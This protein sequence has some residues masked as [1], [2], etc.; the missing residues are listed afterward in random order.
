MVLP[1]INLLTWAGLTLVYFVI[2]ALGT[3]NTIATTKLWPMTAANTGTL[4]YIIGVIG[5]YVCVTEG[6]INIVPI[7]LGAWLG[8]YYSVIWEIK[9][10]RK[11][12]KK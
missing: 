7:A 4:M 8:Q 10:K 9:L 2:E 5:S 12:N 1:H 3:K 11:R 6:L